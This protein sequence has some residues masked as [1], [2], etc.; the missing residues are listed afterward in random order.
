MAL[1]AAEKEAMNHPNELG[2]GMRKRKNL[3]PDSKLR[4]V[5]AEFM[6]GTLHSSDG[7]IVK[8]R[9]QALAIAYSEMAAIHE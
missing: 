2:A 5:M 3:P 7:K 9:K 1:T 8:D 4:V 6:R